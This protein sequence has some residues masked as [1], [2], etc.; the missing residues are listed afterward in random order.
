MSVTPNPNFRIHMEGT[1]GAGKS[2]FLSQFHHNPHVTFIQEDLERWQLVPGVSAGQANLLEKFYVDPPR[3]GHAFEAYVLMTKAEGH[4]L[5]VPTPIKIME[6]SVHSAAH[7]FSKL[8]FG[9][10]MLT[11]LEHGL[12]LDHYRHHIVDGRCDVDLW[13]YLRTP[14]EIAFGRVQKRGRAEEIGV[15][16]LDY[17]ES[18][19]KQYDDFMANVSEPVIVIDGSGTVDEVFA[20]TKEKIEAILP[21]TLAGMLTA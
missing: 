10:G 9:Q 18:L 14:A 12:L 8:L 17:L 5:V 19:E 7:V 1:I 3:W 15:L 2:T 13:V 21:P 16:S 20:Q 4:Q 11:E 6:R